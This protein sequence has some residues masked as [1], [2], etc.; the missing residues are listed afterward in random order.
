MMNKLRVSSAIE[1]TL[2]FTT[3]ALSLREKRCVT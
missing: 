3:D 2:Y 1:K